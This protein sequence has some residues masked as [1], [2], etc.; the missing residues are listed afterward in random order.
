MKNHLI[1]INQ[2][3]YGE[4]KEQDGHPKIPYIGEH[5]ERKRRLGTYAY[6]RNNRRKKQEQEHQY[7]QYVASWAHFK[8]PYGFCI[9]I[10]M[11]EPVNKKERCEEYNK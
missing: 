11:Q 4:E 6:I 8:R 2:D 7:K 5:T 9:K 3:M 10:K 1:D